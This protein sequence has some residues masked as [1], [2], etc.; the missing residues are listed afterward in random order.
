MDRLE[1]LDEAIGAEKNL[2]TKQR[3]LAVRAVLRLEYRTEQAAEIFDVTV[4]CIRNW[5]AKF[6]AGGPKALRNLPKSG[7]PPSA[8][9]DKIDNIISEMADM[10]TTPERLCE[11]IYDRTGVRFSLGHIRRLMRQSGV[12]SKSPRCCTSTVSPGGP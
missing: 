5:V 10:Y 11:E 4:R 8:P 2:K 1:E 3:M 12:S 9:R 7:R 6:K